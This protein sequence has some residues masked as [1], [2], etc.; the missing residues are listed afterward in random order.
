MYK[1]LSDVTILGQSGPGSN[2]NEGVLCI[3]HSSNITRVSA[4]DGLVSY[5]GQGEWGGL[6]PLKRCNQYILQHQPTG[7]DHC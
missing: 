2:G 5:P 3:P 7:A 6:S 4:S 1:I